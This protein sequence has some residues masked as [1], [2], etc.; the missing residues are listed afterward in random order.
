MYKENI[1]LFIQK[2][3]YLLKNYIIYQDNKKLVLSCVKKIP[4]LIH[5]SSERLK[6]DRDVVK[7]AVKNY[8]IELHDIGSY[9]KKF[10][11]D[12]EIV[13]FATIFKYP[14]AIMYASPKLFNDINFICS[15]CLKRKDIEIL[16][17][18]KY[19]IFSKKNILISLKGKYLVNN[20]G[21]LWFKNIPICLQK[22]IS[23][24]I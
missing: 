10:L 21:R 11:E 23:N 9:N 1:P 13:F 16:K 19:K 20:Y 22:K 14:S 5:S 18:I 6:N 2:N 17:F 12:K 8:G 4:W 3:P 7:E 24:F 15:I